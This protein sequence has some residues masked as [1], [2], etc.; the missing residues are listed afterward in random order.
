MNWRNIGKGLRTVAVGLVIA[1]G[2][3]ALNYFTGT[4]WTTTLGLSPGAGAIVG[5]AIIALRA[6][7]TTPIF[8]KS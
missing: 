5:A 8:A 6:V 3:A 2:P 4:D 1:V 7:T